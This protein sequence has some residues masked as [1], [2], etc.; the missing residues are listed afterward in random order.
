MG[1]NA[2]PIDPELD[3]SKVALDVVMDSSPELDDTEPV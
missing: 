3:V 1:F 2:V